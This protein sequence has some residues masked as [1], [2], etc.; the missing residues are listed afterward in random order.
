MGLA[1]VLPAR[2][3][4]CSPS[5]DSWQ[6]L[7]G[8]EEDRIQAGLKGID[9]DTLGGSKGGSGEYPKPNMESGN[10]RGLFHPQGS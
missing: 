4:G 5:R 2:Q 3:R 8:T 10:S 1:R 6:I 9:E 7:S